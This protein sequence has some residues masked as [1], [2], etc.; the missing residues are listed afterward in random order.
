[1]PK[2][3]ASRL[4]KDL[5]PMLVLLNMVEAGAT[6]SFGAKAGTRN[7]FQGHDFSLR[8]H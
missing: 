4:I 6:P 5:A 2:E 1:M 3:Q 8:N 7:G